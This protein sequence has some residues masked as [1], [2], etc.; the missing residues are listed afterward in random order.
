MSVF[1]KQCAA[2]FKRKD[3]C[4][5][6]TRIQILNNPY[7]VHVHTEKPLCLMA[8]ANNESFWT[9]QTEIKFWGC[10]YIMLHG[11]LHDMTYAQRSPSLNAP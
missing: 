1:L 7:T 11:S 8:M 10:K 9:L 6:V 5:T 3:K 4:K 2:L